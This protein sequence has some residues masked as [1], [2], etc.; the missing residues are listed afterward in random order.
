M[1]KNVLANENGMFIPFLSIRI[2][3]VS[4]VKKV[5]NLEMDPS[6]F[7]C[8]ILIGIK[9]CSYYYKMN[10]NFWTDNDLA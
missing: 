9:K 7:K 1:S 2:L 10:S 3:F 6:I 5:V 8:N 4:Y